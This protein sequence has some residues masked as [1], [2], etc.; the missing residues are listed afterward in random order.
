MERHREVLLESYLVYRGDMNGD[1]ALDY[2]E[3]QV[4]YDQIQSALRQPTPRK[5]VQE[6]K[7]AMVTAQLP[8]PMISKQVWAAADG[9]PFALKNPSNP[10]TEEDIKAPNEPMYSYTDAAHNRKPGFDFVEMCLTKDFIDPGHAD[11]LVEA[12]LFFQLLAREYPYCGDTLLTILIPASKSGLHHLLPPPSHPKYSEIAHNLHKYAYTVSETSSEFI[13]AKSANELK[14]GFNRALRTL[15]H[16]GLA[17]FCV[18]DDVESGGSIAVQAMDAQFRGI[19]QGYF[20]GLTADKGATPLENPD[21]I[22]EI[23]E[24]GLNF[25]RAAAFKG[26]PGYEKNAVLI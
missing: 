1:G 10:M 3:R 13:M 23:N 25:W 14:K 20:G 17:Q 4:I 18:N 11:T 26:G 16:R 9:Y 19:L 15:K 12:R 2:N 24:Q 21:S 22:G 5:T 8:L 6:Q 7:N